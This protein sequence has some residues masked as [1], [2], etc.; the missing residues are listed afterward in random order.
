M[1]VDTGA[2]ITMVTKGWAEAHSL[3]NKAGKKIDMW[4]AARQELG[5]LGVT[6]FTV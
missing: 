1:M 5:V 4:G 3:T 2:A 6:S